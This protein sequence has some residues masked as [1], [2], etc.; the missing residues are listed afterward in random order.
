MP[1]ARV[2]VGEKTNRS[3]RKEALGIAK[4]CY[5]GPKVMQ[6]ILDAKSDAEISNI[7]HDARLGKFKKIA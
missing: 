2:D 3:Y 6:A 1:A 4:D 7:L 5:Y